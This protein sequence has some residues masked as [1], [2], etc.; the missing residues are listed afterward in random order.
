MAATGHLQSDY[1]SRSEPL[2]CQSGSGRSRQRMA[3]GISILF[4][5]RIVR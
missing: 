4:R 2:M 3:I 5:K 1:P